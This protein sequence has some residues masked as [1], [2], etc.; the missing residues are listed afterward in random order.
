MPC[1]YDRESVRKYA[2]TGTFV[3][4]CNRCFSFVADE[5]PDIDDG[6]DGVDDFPEEEDEGTSEDYQQFRPNNDE[7]ESER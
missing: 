4:L 6:L 2:S 5:I 7:S 1:L 3:D